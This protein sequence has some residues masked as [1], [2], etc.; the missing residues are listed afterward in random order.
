MVEVQILGAL[1]LFTSYLKTAETQT[2]YVNRLKYFFNHLELPGFN[3]KEQAAY[4]VTKARADEQWSLGCII[5]F[6]NHYKKKIEKKEITST[7]LTDYFNAIQS[8][9]EANDLHLNWK[10]IRA[11]LPEP[12]SRANDRAPTLEEIRKLCQHSDRRVRAIVYV[13]CSSGTRVGTW[14]HFKWKH[15]IPITNAEYL[16]W[17]KR[18]EI[19]STGHSN[20]VISSGDKEEQEKIIAA[21]LVVYADEPEQY[22]SFI[23]PEAYYE[24]KDYMEYRTSFGEK[25]TGES[26][27]IRDLWK[28]TNVKYGA[29]RALATN[30]KRLSQGAIKRLLSRAIWQQNLRQPLQE[31]IRRHEFKTTHSFRKYF[32][33][34]AE[35]FMRPLHVEL[36]MGRDIGVSGSYL[37]PTEQEL[38]DDY[39]KAVDGLTISTNQ[40]VAVQQQKQVT[41]LIEKSEQKHAEKDREAENIKRELAELKEEQQKFIES[42]HTQMELTVRN[43]IEK[44]LGAAEKQKPGIKKL[45]DRGNYVAHWGESLPPDSG[46]SQEKYLT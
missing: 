32:K 7:T 9:Y 26:W 23:T 2:Q 46:E 15:V 20:I 30:P 8:F 43:T 16:R 6:I 17:K 25:I 42:F 22:Y 29:K 1:D 3:M 12:R 41:E 31:G 24:L 36:L 18:Q 33:T 28:T 38:L 5:S 40:K 13:M 11:G 35:N 21:K 44:E 45:I 27:L 37:R 14:E 34:H 10:R 4:F 39:V 19:Q